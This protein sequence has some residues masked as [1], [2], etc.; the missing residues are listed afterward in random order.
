MAA[1]GGLAAVRLWDTDGLLVAFPVMAYSFTAHPYYLGIYQN[2]QGGSVRRMAEVT[3]QV[4]QNPRGGWGG[5]GG[6]G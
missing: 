5:R 3:D 2:M 1:Q 6:V 4:R